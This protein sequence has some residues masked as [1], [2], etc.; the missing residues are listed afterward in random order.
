MHKYFQRWST[1]YQHSETGLVLI[2]TAFAMVPICLIT[3]IAFN[4]GITDATTTKLQSLADSASLDAV[5]YLNVAVP[6]GYA[7]DLQYLTAEAQASEVRNGYSSS[8]LPLTVQCGTATFTSTGTTFA[9]SG[10]SS[11][12]GAN[13]VKVT[14]SETINLLQTGNTN[15]ARSA[16][17][18]D[19]PPQAGFSIG[20]YLASFTSQDSTLNS[21]LSPLGSSGL[22]LCAVCYSGLATTGVS[23]L[24]LINASGGVLTPSNVLSTSLTYSQLETLM[25]TILAAQPA[26]TDITNALSGLTQLL[27]HAS[28]TT[29]VELCKVIS[30][31]GSTCANP[32]VST[33]ALA[34]SGNILQTLTYAAELANGGS[35]IDLGTNLNIS[36]VTDAKVAITVIQPPQYAFGPV[37]VSATTAQVNET[38]TLTLLSGIA[39]SIPLTGVV[40]QATLNAVNCSNNSPTSVVIKPATTSVVSTSIGASLLSIPV[41]TVSLGIAGGSAPS[42]GLTYLPTYGPSDAQSFGTTTPTFTLGTPVVSNVVDWLLDGVAVNAV[43]KLLAPALAPLFQDLGLSVGGAT[44][45]VTTAACGGLQLVQ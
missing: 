35:A 45:A 1:R 44:V 41:A 42:G 22:N 24:Q 25:Q 23:L 7:N 37:G 38:L 39:L 20:S 11:C 3:A 17:A 9:S 10:T 36:G 5:Q 8:T 19:V 30:I 14:P 34:A 6:S 2:M 4:I 15:Y 28:T 12:T 21:I 26:T 33:S 32:A 29:T 13:A 27:L 43:L 16:V 18:A 31:N 40:G